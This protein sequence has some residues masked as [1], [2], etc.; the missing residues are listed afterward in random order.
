MLQGERIIMAHSHDINF[1]V[2]AP[3][4]LPSSSGHRSEHGTH[5]YSNCRLDLEI[6]YNMT[7]V[8]RV[9]TSVISQPSKGRTRTE[10][11]AIQDL[12]F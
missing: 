1:R 11:N 12:C 2:G 10:I 9:T 6:C 8:A 7:L 3:L 4:S 5:C